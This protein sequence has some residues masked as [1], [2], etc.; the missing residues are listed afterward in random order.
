MPYS[1]VAMMVQDAL[2]LLIDRRTFYAFN[3]S[4]LISDKTFQAGFP[5]P[6]KLYFGITFH[7]CP[8]RRS[9]FSRPSS[10]DS[11]TYSASNSHYSELRL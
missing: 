2:I 6:K 11:T 3:S 5:P 10:I 7:L 8:L 9:K 4:V 1:L